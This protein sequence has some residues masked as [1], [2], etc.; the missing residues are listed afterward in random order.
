VSRGFQT[1][2]AVLV[3]TLLAAGLIACGGDGEASSAEE[4]VVNREKQTQNAGPSRDGNQ[5]S[6]TTGKGGGSTGAHSSPAGG[7]ASDFTSK[8]HSDSGGG[9]AQY[10]VKG[11]D[12]SVQEFGEEAA[13]TELEAAATVLH[14]FL[15]ARAEGNWAAACEYL[16]QGAARSFEQVASRLEGIDDSSC[17]GILEGLTNPNARA[18]LKAEA[19]AAD[20]GSLRV[21][22]GRAFV[23]YTGIDGTVMVM[24]MENEGGAWKVATIASTPIS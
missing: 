17:G 11:G 1:L 5:R 20:V 8:Q 22:G 4:S 19:K 14:N 21:E 2:A 3:A 18:A 10:R 13:T 15:D 12:N 7:D 16:S 9:S 24:P 6:A 23:I